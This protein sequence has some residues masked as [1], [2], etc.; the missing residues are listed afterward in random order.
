MKQQAVS[1]ILFSSQRAIYLL[2]EQISIPLVQ[3]WAASSSEVLKQKKQNPETC[4]V[5]TLPASISTHNSQGKTGQDRTGQDRTRQDK[6]RQGKARQGKARQGKAR[7]SKARQG[8][9]QK[10]FFQSPS[11]LFSSGV[12]IA[13]LGALQ[14]L[15]TSSSTPSHASFSPSAAPPPLP[16]PTACLPHPPGTRS[17]LQTGSAAH[18]APPHASSACAREKSRLA[19]ASA[20]LPQRCLEHRSTHSPRLVRAPSPCLPVS[21][22]KS[23]GRSGTGDPRGLGKGPGEPASPPPPCVHETLSHSLP[24]GCSRRAHPPASHGTQAARRTA[25]PTT[26]AP[27]CRAQASS[28]SRPCGPTSTPVNAGGSS[29]FTLTTTTAS[30]ARSSLP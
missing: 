24:A 22:R 30:P 29:R 6:T 18:S 12:S 23:T 17:F 10:S 2:W 1:T 26:S 14:P 11:L 3:D 4:D 13:R 8:K 21:A 28:P 20:R 15:T 25:G 9:Y 27:C 19:Q 16:L 7:Q 5:P